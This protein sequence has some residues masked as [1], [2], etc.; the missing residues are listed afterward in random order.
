M[1]KTLHTMGGVTDIVSA[2]EQEPLRQALV[3]IENLS[4]TG[5]RKWHKAD[6]FFGPDAGADSSKPQWPGNA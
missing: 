1:D 3:D 4:G 6:N 5:R 2:K